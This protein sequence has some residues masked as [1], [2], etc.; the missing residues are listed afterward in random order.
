M[1]AV[2]PAG[3]FPIDG[4][5]LDTWIVRF[6]KSGICASPQTRAL[7]LDKLAANPTAPIVFFSHGWNND[8]AD[9]L[10][11]YKSF[12]QHF[13]KVLQD[14]PMQG[15]APTFVGITWPSMWLPSDSGPQMAGAGGS[16]KDIADISSVAGAVG[17]LV[18]ALPRTTNRQRFY[19]LTE[20]RQV[21]TDEARELARMLQTIVTSSD[22]GAA[23][24]A[25]S[26]DALLRAFGALQSAAGAAQSSDDLGEGGVVTAAGTGAAPAAAGLPAFLDPRWAVR[27]GTL[28]L[29]KDRAGTVGSAG[30]GELLRDMLQRTTGPIH[31]VGHSFGG[32]V[33][34]SAIAALA[35]GT[36]PVQSLL[37]LQPAVSHL[38]FAQTVPGRT[39]S[40]GYRVVL[41]RVAKPILSTFST[42]DFPLHT[43]YHLALLRRADLGE[44]QIAA[45]VT[46]AG[47]PPNAYAALG[48]YGP[49]GADEHLVDGLPA[50]GQDIDPKGKRIVGLDGS[51]DKRIDSHGGVAN[52]YTAWALR[53]L[54]NS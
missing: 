2:R 17:D 8:F 30:A 14:H 39:G 49:R 38:S 5:N 42:H 32:K 52:P 47:N 15:T 45:A 37:L 13:Q 40:G 44:L 28:Y 7:L 50:P 22:D 51:K 3:P 11:L 27:L 4:I 23:E 29:M 48:G 31:A 53:T 16:A 54:M 19:E 41:D 1:P 46:T 43:I 12:L 21:S 25:S 18:E 10:A 33:M 34:L 6:D 36:R 35:N 26:E 20:A 9:A 24:D